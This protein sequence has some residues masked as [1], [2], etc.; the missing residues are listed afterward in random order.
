MSIYF[1][2]QNFFEVTAETWV[3]RAHIKGAGNVQILGGF[4]GYQKQ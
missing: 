4:W 1:F 2:A 3:Y